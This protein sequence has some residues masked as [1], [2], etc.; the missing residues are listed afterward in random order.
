M[1][2][3]HAG[4]YLVHYRHTHDLKSFTLTQWN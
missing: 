2:E 1:H 3:Q 4:L